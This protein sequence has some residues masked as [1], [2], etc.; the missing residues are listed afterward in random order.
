MHFSGADLLVTH[1]VLVSEMYSEYDLDRLN[2][3]VLAFCCF[4][5]FEFL[6]NIFELVSLGFC[7]ALLLFQV[8]PVMIS[9]FVGFLG[10][11]FDFLIVVDCKLYLR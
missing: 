7:G 3:K 1:L 10:S 5:D 2:V 9:V 11:C 4:G 6:V 8:F